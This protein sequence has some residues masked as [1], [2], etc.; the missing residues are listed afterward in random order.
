[1]FQACQPMA[2][3]LDRY[4]YVSVDQQQTQSDSIIEQF[5]EPYR[6]SLSSSMQTIIGYAAVDLL[7]GK[8]ES[9]LGNFVADLCAERILEHSSIEV[10][11]VVLNLGGLRIQSIAEGPIIL[12]KVYELMPFDNTL[13]VVDLL[14]SELYDLFTRISN[15]GGWPISQTLQLNVSGDTTVALVNG[16]TVK[17]DQIYKVGVNNYMAGGG[18]QCFFLEDKKQYDTGY[19]MRDAIKD[20]ISISFEK[21]QK[22]SASLDGRLKLVK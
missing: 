7:K 10:D 5:I 4:I 20:H 18:D 8:P 14:G 22:V 11:F 17:S 21:G 2:P 1:M 3:S 19:L 9:T 6:D 15:A 13:V 16:Q 12:S